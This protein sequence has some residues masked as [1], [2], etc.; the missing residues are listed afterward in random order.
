MYQKLIVH[1]NLI[2]DNLWRKRIR[3]PIKTELLESLN[4]WNVALLESILYFVYL[5]VQRSVWQ[6]S[7]TGVI[8]TGT[9]RAG[10][11]YTRGQG[12]EEE[13]QHVNHVR[14]IAVTPLNHVPLMWNQRILWGLY[15]ASYKRTTGNIAL[16]PQHSV[17]LKE[18]N[19]ASLHNKNKIYISI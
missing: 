4:L 15:L 5:Q 17:I 9:Q 13:T 14:T 2:N 12:H 11:Q 7:G 1:I 16:L 18:K 6:V 19:K 3:K 8:S 10:T